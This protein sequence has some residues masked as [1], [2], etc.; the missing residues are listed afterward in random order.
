MSAVPDPVEAK[1]L[2]H[3]KWACVLSESLLPF[4]LAEGVRTR[5]C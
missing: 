1:C 2:A 4:G 5:G 3:R